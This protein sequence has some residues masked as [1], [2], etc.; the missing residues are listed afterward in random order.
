ML[1]QHHAKYHDGHIPELNQYSNSNR[2][3]SQVASKHRAKY[4]GDRLQELKQ[5]S[6]CHRGFGKDKHDDS[7][8]DLESERRGGRLVVILDGSLFYV[9]VSFS[10]LLVYDT[11]KKKVVYLHLKLKA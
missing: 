11:S 7:E 5:F 4:N 2:G 1:V 9:T 6:G 3:F 10:F 8:S